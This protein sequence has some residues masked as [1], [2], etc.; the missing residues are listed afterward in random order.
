MESHTYNSGTNRGNRRIWIE[1]E[2]LARHG[3]TRGTKVMRTMHDDGRITLEANDDG[4]H[5]VAGTGNRPI[6]DLNGKYHNGWFNGKLRFHATFETG[7][8]TITAC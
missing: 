1:G 5:T 4:R 7:I 3:F 6:L 8:I 2:R